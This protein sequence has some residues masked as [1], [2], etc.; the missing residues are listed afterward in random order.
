MEPYIP[1]SLPPDNIDWVRH[2]ELMGKANRALA[3]YNG[4]LNGMVNQDILLSP[5]TTQEAVLSSKIEG[6]R[7]TLEDVLEYN[8]DLRSKFDTEQ[9]RDIIEVENY[10]L[11][12]NRAVDLLRYDPLTTDTLRE[13]HRIL[14]TGARGRNKEPGKIRTTQNYIGHNGATIE[15]AIFIPPKPEDVGPA[16]QNWETYLRMD[17]KDPIIQLALLKAQFEL[18]HPFLDG[19]GRIGR[20]LVPVIFYYKKIL[21]SPLF[22][23]SAYFEGHQLQYYTRLNA[24][25]REDDWDGWISFFLQAIFEQAENN[26]GKATEILHLYNVMKPKI[27]ETLKSRYSIQV[28]DFL[29]SCPVFTSTKFIKE[30]HIPKQSAVNLIH[31]LEK[32][33]IIVVRKKGKGRTPSSYRFERLLEISQYS[34]YNK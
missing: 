15:S 22:Y 9:T 17:E 20:M 19:N 18:I 11:A 28:L 24:I 31:Q 10:R 3:K 1:R 2:I 16:L 33:E 4:I 29:F 32:D 26:C 7:V 12:M 14:L 23:V 8:A 34:N 5:L 25:S 21:S 13:L 27:D 30:T 6:T